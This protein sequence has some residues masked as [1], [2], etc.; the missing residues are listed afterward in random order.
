MNKLTL[1]ALCLTMGLLSACGPQLTALNEDG[2]ANGSSSVV[3]STTAEKALASLESDLRK[4]TVTATE[5][6][7]NQKAVSATA[8][9]ISL[10]SAQINTIIESARLA[11]ETANLGQSNDLSAIIPVLIKGASLGANAIQLGDSS[12]IA[13]LLS[14]I[15]NSALTSIVNLSPDQI[16]TGD[17]KGLAQSI[18]A[19]L[20]TAGVGSSNATSVAQTIIQSLLGHI[21]STDIDSSGFSSVIQ[22]IAQGAIAG[23]NNNAGT[24]VGS[25]IFQS[26][27]KGL[28]S[29][30]LNGIAAIVSSLGNSNNASDLLKTFINAFT[31]G[32]QSG[33]NQVSSSKSLVSTLLNSILTG[34]NSSAGTP[35]PSG[36]SWLTTLVGA[37]VPTLISTLIKVLII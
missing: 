9:K 31:A 7:V 24:N 37:V 26:I 30:S 19:N 4:G 12:L 20:A 35:P 11:L 2:T 34:L 25:T 15:G 6:S 36:S 33:L 8:E 32:S 23:L 21:A 16:S 28:G 14:V 1:T 5:S 27:L 22:S 3:P 18:F 13:K 17:L 10:N 29:G